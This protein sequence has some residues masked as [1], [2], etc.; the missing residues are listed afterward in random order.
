MENL[1]H[2]QSDYQ[3][4]LRLLRPHNNQNAQILYYTDAVTFGTPGRCGTRPLPTP[5]LPLALY[6]SALPLH[7]L[8][9]SCPHHRLGHPLQ[10]ASLL[11]NAICANL[12]HRH[13]RLLR[14][15]YYHLLVYHEPS[16]PCRAQCWRGMDDRVRQLWRFHRHV[17]VCGG[18]CAVVSE[19]VCYL[20]GR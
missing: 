16:R 9:P 4:S 10:G 20:F 1:I 17:F 5:S 2:V 6:W 3:C 19:R 13:G 18:R 14:R 11:C 12:P 15:P 7:R 8:W